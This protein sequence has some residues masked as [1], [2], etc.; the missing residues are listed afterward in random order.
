MILSQR[1][2]EVAKREPGISHVDI[3]TGAAAMA[4]AFPCRAIERASSRFWPG[5]MRPTV[6]HASN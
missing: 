1:R 3:G 6:E 2:I 5:L 4:V